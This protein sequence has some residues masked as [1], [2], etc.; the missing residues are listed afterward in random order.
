MN[1]NSI[2]I[3]NTLDDGE[4]NFLQKKINQ[5][6][7]SYNWY[8]IIQP[9]EY[10]F[11]CHSLM[12]AASQFFDFSDVVGYELWSH[13]NSLPPGGWHYDKD[14]KVFR[15][16]QIYKFPICSIV[17][18]PVIDNLVGGELLLEQD[19]ISPK[20]NRLIIFKPNIYHYVKEFTGTRY[21]I[22]INPW[23][24]ELGIVSG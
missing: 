9:H 22:V 23:T 5:K 4:L 7:I 19:I 15:E 6:D 12:S 3:D 24:T 11:I 13:F 14:E 2:I 10:D 17:Y 1:L 8:D 20:L 16:K 18:Y 21:S